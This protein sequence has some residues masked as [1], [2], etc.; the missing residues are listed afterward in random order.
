MRRVDHFAKISDSTWKLMEGLIRFIL[1]WFDRLAHNLLNGGVGGTTGG[2]EMMVLREVV[3]LWQWRLLMIVV[4]CWRGL[5]VNGIDQ[6]S[7]K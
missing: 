6:R 2:L 3:I 5:V 1:M 4:E 7:L